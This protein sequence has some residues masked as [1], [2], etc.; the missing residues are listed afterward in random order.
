MEA[1]A[2]EN[3][4]GTSGTQQPDTGPTLAPT[5]TNPEIE[6]A[7]MAYLDD[8]PAA[9]RRLQEHQLQ[10]AQTVGRPGV[11]T[12]NIQML[13]FGGG[14]PY[15]PALLN[16][17]DYVVGFDG[18]HD[19]IHAQNWSRGKK[20]GIT[21]ILVLDSLAATLASSIFSPGSVDVETYFEVGPEVTTLAISVFILGYAFG[22]L[23][24]GP[25]S[26]LFG[27]RL[28]TLVGSCGFGIFNVAVA[29][30]KDYQ[31]LVICRFFAGV[32][33]SCPLALVAAVL[34]DMFNNQSRGI[35]VA[36]I[37]ATIL[38]GPLVGP[39]IGGFIAKSYLGWR[40][41][42]YVPAFMAFT[43]CVLAIIFQD[44]SH[45]PRISMYKGS[46]LRRQT[47][48][49][50]IHAKQEEVELSVKELMTKNLSRPLQLLLEEPVILVITVCTSFIYGITYLSLS[51]FATIFGQTHHFS[52]GVA[53]LPCLGMIVGVFLELFAVICTNR[54]YVRQL[55]ANNDVPIPEWRM[56]LAM[57][58]SVCFA[59]DIYWAA[60]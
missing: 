10:H 16:A 4:D 23:A 39:M 17:D 43:S 9:I 1:Q 7:M 59:T 30:S 11:P 60:N 12:I 27:R 49:W 41:T 8:H 28:P 36:I 53:G 37:S 15:P 42:A 56:P 3:V 46:E 55:R 40:W 18:H 52:R 26:E 34:A 47:R 54:N 58:G 21:A 32:F 51:A 31:T 50:G 24:F 14:K 57:L 25:L 35:A 29:V 5:T 44:E 13:P 2:K 48:N 6:L 22:P 19:P 20:V 33:G 45:A 38:C